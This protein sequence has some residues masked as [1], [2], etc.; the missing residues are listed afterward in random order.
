MRQAFQD[1]VAPRL[2]GQ[3][4][5]KLL[6]LITAFTQPGVVGTVFAG[7][8][9]VV[10]AGV[11]LSD[12]KTGALL[13][14]L[15]PGNVLGAAGAGGGVLGVVANAAIDQSTGADRATRMAHE[16]AQNYVNFITATPNT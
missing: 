16:F 2:Q 1:I 3:R 13:Y 10:S 7:G 12:A 4:P 15:P 9:A 8:K 14:S 5:V 6:I 11:V